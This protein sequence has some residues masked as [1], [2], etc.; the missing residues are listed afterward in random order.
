MIQGD[1]RR[2]PR[3]PLRVQSAMTYEVKAMATG[4][5]EESE[6]QREIAMLRGLCHPNIVRLIEVIGEPA[7][8][9]QIPTRMTSV[10]LCIHMTVRS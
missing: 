7:C 4:G 3:L 2:L 8:N 6:A 9:K 5:E 1:P 10:M